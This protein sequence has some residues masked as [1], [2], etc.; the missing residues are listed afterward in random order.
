MVAGTLWLVATLLQRQN[1]Y[2]NCHCGRLSFTGSAPAHIGLLADQG[3]WPLS[4][5][6]AC[7]LVLIFILLPEAPLKSKSL[8]SSQ[9]TLIV[10]HGLGGGVGLGEPT[11]CLTQQGPD[12]RLECG[13]A[14]YGC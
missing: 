2:L 7:F 3:P 4:I 12:N 11:P 5:R 6:V 10:S 14:Y 8:V 9:C 13:K 1:N